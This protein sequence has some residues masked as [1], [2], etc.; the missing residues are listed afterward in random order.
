M[1]VVQ[2]AVLLI[3]EDFVGLRDSLELLIGLFTL[4]VGNLIGVG[5]ECSLLKEV[6][7]VNNDDLDGLRVNIPCDKPS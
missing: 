1:L 3:A 5:S 6:L 4:V 7:A 2:L